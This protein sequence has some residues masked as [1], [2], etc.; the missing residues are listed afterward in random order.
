[1]QDARLAQSEGVEARLLSFRLSSWLRAA[2]DSLCQNTLSLCVQ[3]ELGEQKLTFYLR[4][5]G[6]KGD[7]P[8]LRMAYGL[9]TGF[10]STRICHVCPGHDA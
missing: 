7:W 5:M 2:L 1:M 4:F 8:F 10:S 6:C 9:Q 3:V